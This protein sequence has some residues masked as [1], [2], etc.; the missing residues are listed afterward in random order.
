MLSAG[1]GVKKKK[2]GKQVNNAKNIFWA[3]ANANK[4]LLH[5]LIAAREVSLNSCSSKGHSP[6]YLGTLNS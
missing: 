5:K 1:S 6:L 2:N 3:V 4:A